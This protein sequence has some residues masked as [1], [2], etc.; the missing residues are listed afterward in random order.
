LQ[1]SENLTIID[2]REKNRQLTQAYQE[3][4]AAQAA[5]IEKEKLEH[6]LELASEIQC[7]ILPEKLPQHPGLDFGA[8]MVPARSVGGDFYDFILLDKHR[9]GIVVGDVTDKGMPAAL[10]MALTYSSL[11]T[12]AFRYRNPGDALRAVN[13]HLLQINRSNM[14][15]TLLYGILDYQTGEFTYARAGHPPPLVLDSRHRPVDIPSNLGQPVGLFNPFALDEQKICLPTQGSLLI[16]S[17][18][19]SET[20][21]GSKDF[22]PLPELCASIQEGSELTAQDFCE[23]LWRTVGGAEGEWLIQDDFTLVCVRNL[24]PA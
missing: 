14:F 12:E 22:P 5:I 15:V 6:E 24:N 13:R 3:L 8:L 4:K 11:R 9:L 20:I 2:L 21:E 1:Q 17:D 18:G 16:Y 10:F 19:L 23:R 7:S